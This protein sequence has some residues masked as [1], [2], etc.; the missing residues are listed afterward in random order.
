MKRLG[1]ALSSAICALV[2][3]LA[4]LGGA[5]A[6]LAL[7]PAQRESV[8]QS[9]EFFEP[10]PPPEAGD[11]AEIELGRRLFHDPLL[12]GDGAV[13]CSTCHD[14]RRG[15]DDGRPVS[16]GVGGAS[17]RRNSLSVYNLDGHV[18]Y[19]WDG[20]AR[21]LED[22]IDGPM[23]AA[24]EMGATWEDVITRLSA[25]PEYRALFAALTRAQ[26]SRESVTSALVAYE[27]SLT[28]PD[29]RFDAF[30]RGD[31]EALTPLEQRGMVRFERFGCVS[32][33]QGPLLGA[34]LYQRLGVYN[35]Y[36]PDPDHRD[37]GRYGVTGA[38]ADQDVFKVPSLRNVELT[39][40][41]FHD[42][43]IATLEEA[44]STMAY[45]Q[46][47]RTLSQQEVVELVAF[48]KTLTGEKLR[49][50]NPDYVGVVEH[51]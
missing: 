34:N 7:T 18:S 42:G 32:C 51:P 48:L 27:R 29:S 16:I 11:P 40:P 38:V 2:V 12:S 37:V 9:S 17:G 4:Q 3:A 45:Y 36:E 23:L 24:D 21:T 14:V 15:G 47:G 22:Q 8:S 5:D 25:N 49:R 31:G 46:L 44:V 33:H 13:S 39:A 20:R 1:L 30:L 10:L 35:A 28:T 26:P 6:A 19:F 50:L 43:R 41:Y